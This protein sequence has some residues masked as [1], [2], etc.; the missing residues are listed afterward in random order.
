VHAARVLDE[1]AAVA[2][3][4][5][6]VELGD[7]RLVERDVVMAGTTDLVGARL[8]EADL[9]GHLAADHLEHGDGQRV[10]ALRAA[11][12]IVRVLGGALR[13]QHER[14]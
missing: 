7:R 9:L 11:R 3:L 6:G 8:Q 1:E 14:P 12:R 5:A 4:D 2:V 10:G 13:A